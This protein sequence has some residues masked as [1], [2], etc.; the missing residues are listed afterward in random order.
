MLI[1]IRREPEFTDWLESQR[2]KERA[3]VL[4]RIAKIEQEGYF[5]DA[6]VLGAGLAELRW[7]NGRRVY[8]AKTGESEITLILGG[9]KNGQSQDI[10]EARKILSR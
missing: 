8:F 2:P 4:A 5:G 1:Q 6:K 7:K 10:K 9:N 3:Q